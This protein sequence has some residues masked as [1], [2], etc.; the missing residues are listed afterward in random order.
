MRQNHRAELI[1]AFATLIWGATFVII[2][3]GLK[4]CSPLLF[5]G[6]RFIAAFLVM[7]AFNR[8]KFMASGADIWKRGLVLGV[9]NYI[10]YAAQTI[11]LE[12]TTVAKSSLITYFFAVLTPPLHYLLTGKKPNRGN[13][14]GLAVVFAGMIII[15]SPKAEGINIGDVLTLA[16][17]LSYA[18]YIVLLDKYPSRGDAGVLVSIQ[19]L[20]TG[21][22]GLASAPLAETVYIELNTSLLLSL[23]YLSFLGS[24]VSIFLINRFQYYTTPTRAVIIYSLEP[25]F[26]VILGI[27]FLAESSAPLKMAGG[28]VILAGILLSELWEQIRY[29]REKRKGD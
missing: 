9:L 18:F 12:Y 20:L 16:S 25:V 3:E 22:L 29:M 26:S 24:A 2:K 23:A 7:F 4:S 6:I 8:K 5:I 28:A 10:A 1:L 17:A 13:L 15:T 27:I 21:V 11:G 14:A 19:F